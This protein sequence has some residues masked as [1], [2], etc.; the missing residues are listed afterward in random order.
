MYICRNKGSEGI[1]PSS[2]TSDNTGSIKAAFLFLLYTSFYTECVSC[3]QHG[4]NKE[5]IFIWKLSCHRHLHHHQDCG[6]GLGLLFQAGRMGL[7]TPLSQKPGRVKLGLLITSP[8]HPH[9][10]STAITA[11]SPV[12]DWEQ[13]TNPPK[14]TCLQGGCYILGGMMAAHFKIATC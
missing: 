5:A 7:K 9:P 11:Q 10:P 3:L 8:S 1:N 14:A 13:R 2:N 6:L 4:K 12:L